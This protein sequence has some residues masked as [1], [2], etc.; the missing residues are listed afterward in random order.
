MTERPGRDAGPFCFDASMR[1]PHGVAASRKRH[2]RGFQQPNGWS[3]ED[4]E[5]E[6]RRGG[7]SCRCFAGS[8]CSGSL[9]MRHRVEGKSLFNER[10]AGS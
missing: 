6:G 7:K 3:S 2:S 9:R 8:T 5:V 4:D 10:G 1:A